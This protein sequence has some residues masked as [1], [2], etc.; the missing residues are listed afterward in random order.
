MPEPTATPSAGMG[1]IGFLPFILIILIFYFILIRPQVKKEKE[2]EKMRENLKKGD[3]VIIAGGICGSILDF[4]GDRVILKV[5]DNTKLTVLRSSI[6]F[7]QTTSAT[8][9]ELTQKKGF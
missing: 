2:L 1:L 6:S 5:D 9:G 7:V 3:N 8:P 4:R